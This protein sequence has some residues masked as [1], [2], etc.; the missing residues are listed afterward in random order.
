MQMKKMVI[1]Q[2]NNSTLMS[3]HNSFLSPI[4]N[5]KWTSLQKN[6]KLFVTFK[7]I[8]L[9]FHL[10]LCKFKSK[11]IN[12]NHKIIFSKRF[13]PIS[14]KMNKIFSVFLLIFS[15]FLYGQLFAQQA[16]NRAI[17]RG[18][19]LE[20]N[21]KWKQAEDVFQSIIE[22]YPNDPRGYHYQASI[23]LW[24][25][26]SNIDKHDLY[27]F[28]AYSDTTIEKAQ[29]ILEK[30]SN[31]EK[32]LYTLGADYS[33]RTIAFTKAE[34]FLDAIWSSKKS[35]SYL[36]ETLKVDSTFYDA[37]LGLGLY[38]FAVAQIPSAFRWAFSLAGI[39]GDK[40]VGLKYIEIAA[41]HGDYTK[42]EAQ[43][44]LSQILSDFLLDYPKSAFYLENLVDRYPGNSLFNYSLAVLQIKRRN[45]AD[46]KKI[47]TKI[48]KG[49]DTTFKQ[50]IAFSNFLMGD[51]E[52]KQNQFKTAITAYLK[53]LNNTVNNDYK[54][55]ASY[56]LAICY[57]IVGDHA[58]AVK[59][60]ELTDKGNPDIEDDVFAEKRGKIYVK[61][62]LSQNEIKLIKYSN[63]IDNAKY[64]AAY[65]SLSNL[66]GE[67]QNDKL[68][69]EVYFYL[70]E[71]AYSLGLYKESLNFS[72]TAKVLDNFGETWIKPF[73]C[74]YAALASKKL[75][76][77]QAVN[78]FIAEANDYSGYDYE[79]KLKNMI[80]AL[81]AKD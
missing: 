19:D 80:Y 8:T 15:F 45:L 50:I 44:F 46:A 11:E 67:L 52:F 63:M 9:N 7:S 29:K 20:Y 66:L 23:Y 1:L 12:K 10:L 13:N 65:D 76:D 69:A 21:F 32:I 34:K 38:N 41:Q 2:M 77:E 61:R 49:K 27:K 22:K 57:D 25:Y 60:F 33:F 4:K 17:K 43:Y 48:I 78:N 39:K 64:K 40:E 68:K 37:Y 42:V 30:Q 58:D 35:E 56:R 81:T 18:L 72:S 55:I 73:A 31:N 14:Y 36:S 74:Y 47:L 59:Y 16:L 71:A 70:S 5:F 28:T 51:V 75:K 6:F 62:T 79:K 53:F 54:G 26:L 3:Q 24:R